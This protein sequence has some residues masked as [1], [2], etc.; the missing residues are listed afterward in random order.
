MDPVEE[1]VFR[2]SDDPNVLRDQGDRGWFP[3]GVSPEIDALLFGLDSDGNRL[4]S[5]R[6]PS[7]GRFDGESNW[8]SYLVV[9]EVNDAREI[10]EENFDAL[11]TRA[12][13]IFLNEE[14]ANFDLHMV[15]DSEIFEWVNNQV[16]LSTILP[17]PTPVPFDSQF[18]GLSQLGP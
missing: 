2:Y 9:A 18:S 15:L 1:V 17:S 6:T 3:F 14:R 16:R 8:W 12:M 11:A 4:L 5:L 7:E 10:D 13:T